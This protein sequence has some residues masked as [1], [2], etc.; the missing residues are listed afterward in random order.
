MTIARRPIAS[1]EQV[2]GLQ[3]ALDGKAAAA[4]E[5]A[6]TGVHGIVVSAT[7][8][9]GLGLNVLSANTGAENAVLGYN[10]LRANTSGK[11]NVAVGNTAMYSNTTGEQNTAIGNGVLYASNGSNNTAVGYAAMNANTSGTNNAAFGHAALRLNSV[12]TNNVAF[13]NSAAYAMTSGAY[14]CVF[15]N[16][17]LYSVTTTDNNVAFGYNAGRYLADGSTANEASSRGTF[18]G[19]GTRA[20]TAGATNETVIGSTAIGGGSNTVRLGNASVT[21]WLPGATNV[22]ALGNASTAFKELYMT[23]GTNNWKLTVDATGPVWTSL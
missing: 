4:H 23:D 3:G 5:T 1:I 21:A 8:S 22:C 13:G 19:Y 6:L 16:N 9:V 10:A 2:D 20:S 14:N 15:G 12:G 18:I 7:S 17:A 11:R